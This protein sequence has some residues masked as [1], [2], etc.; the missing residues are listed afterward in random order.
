MWNGDKPILQIELHEGINLG[1]LNSL[2][3]PFVVFRS[4]TETVQ[5]KVGL[6]SNEKFVW[7]EKLSIV[8]DPLSALSISV[9]S[10]QAE[11][12][13]LVS[14]VEYQFF[15]LS[16][17]KNTQNTWISFELSC[18]NSL[19][20]PDI[21]NIISS[22]IKRETG[23]SPQINITLT[24]I[25]NNYLRITEVKVEGFRIILKSKESYTLYYVNM[26]RNDGKTIKKQLRF[27]QVYEFKSKLQNVE[28]RL[29]S[30]DFP[31]KTYLEFLAC[32]W[33]QLGRFDPRVIERRR[34]GIEEVLQFVIKKSENI[35]FETLNNFLNIE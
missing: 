33:P 27:S 24:F 20:N 11:Q 17:L 29:N 14:N 26:I 5:S 34:K 28:H 16:G 6:V 19:V 31:G 2:I 12:N 13:L 32:V 25:H 21:S 23:N 9:F 15:E 18:K 1:L 3:K 22:G 4:G 30:I 7:N 8:L 10:A 35:G